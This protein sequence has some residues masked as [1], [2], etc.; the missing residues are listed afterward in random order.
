MGR[1]VHVGY[2]WRRIA[3]G[4]QLGR[5]ILHVLGL[6]DALGSK[7]YQFAAGIDDAL[8][9]SHTALGVIRIYRSHRLDADGIRAANANLADTGF[10]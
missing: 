9:L 8:G 1:E 4:L 7:T 6:T 10:G 3:I 2:E 5:D